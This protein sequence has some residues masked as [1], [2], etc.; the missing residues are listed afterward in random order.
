MAERLIP[1]VVDLGFTHIEFLPVS[2]HPYDPSWGYQTTGL[3]APSAR[4]GEPAGFAR[5]VDGA[6]RESLL[7]EIAVQQIAQPRIVVD[8]EDLRFGLSHGAIVPARP[9]RCQHIVSLYCSNR[10]RNNLLQNAPIRK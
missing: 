1:Y 6:H 10:A 8:D 2:E 3:Y 5:F 7:V 4:F 9:V